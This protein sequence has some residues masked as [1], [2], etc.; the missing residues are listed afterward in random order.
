MIDTDAWDAEYKRL[1]RKYLNMNEIQAEL[2]FKSAPDFDRGYSAFWY[3][4]EELNCESIKRKG[5]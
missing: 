2:H 4:K 5:K 3:I 1:C